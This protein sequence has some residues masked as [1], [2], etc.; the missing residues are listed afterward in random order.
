MLKFGI[1]LLAIILLFISFFLYAFAKPAIKEA[2]I[3]YWVVFLFV[4]C[5]VCI[6]QENE[7]YAFAEIRNECHFAK[8]CT[9]DATHTYY[10]R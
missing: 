10:L 4:T 1:A 2:V 5:I 7:K 9:N 6:H 3:W 8:S